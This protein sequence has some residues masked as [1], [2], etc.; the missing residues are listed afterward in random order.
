MNLK[1]QKL[2]E[3]L[4]KAQK[5]KEEKN[6]KILVQK[7][8]KLNFFNKINKLSN[9]FNSA[10]KNQIKKFFAKDF[11]NRLFLNRLKHSQFSYTENQASTHQ[12]PTTKFSFK[13]QSKKP[14]EKTDKLAPIK[15]VIP[16]FVKFLDN[17]ITE[18][19]QQTLSKLKQ[20]DLYS[21]FCN[22]YKNY[23][24]K[25]QIKPKKEI[26]KNL[27][28][29]SNYED[30]KGEY[31]SR[32][33]SLIKKKYVNHITTSL[34]N[35]H[36]MFKLIYLLRVLKLNKNVAKGRFLRELIRKWRFSAFVK[37]MARK[38]LE[39][40][41]KNLHVSYLQMANEVFGDEDENN[42]SVIKEF[43]RFGSN[44]GMFNS[45]DAQM[46][47]EINKRYYSNV[48]KKYVFN[49]TVYEENKTEE[50]VVNDSKISS[51]EKI[52]DSSIKNEDFKVQNES[53]L[54]KTTEG[55]KLDMSIDWLAK[56]KSH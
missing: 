11:L 20:N 32:L 37:K 38:K 26:I 4:Q 50:K 34:E 18:R 3:T 56:Y 44:L 25:K 46:N 28:E 15:K 55:Q 31:I 5:E 7:I 49:S 39:L 10:Q 24:L 12:A 53:S 13:S 23:A 43:E 45:E 30:T 1:F 29:K 19:K 17:K 27:K 21:R 35:P 40:M 22:L 48:T 14:S 47:E 42:P 8:Y 6:K 9:A 51:M 16:F 52:E 41:Y 33:Y 2:K 54:S 36:R